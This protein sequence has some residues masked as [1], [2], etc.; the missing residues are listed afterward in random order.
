MSTKDFAKD[1]GDAQ[2]ELRRYCDLDAMYEDANEY[3]AAVKRDIDAGRLDLERDPVIRPVNPIVRMRLAGR[4][5]SCEARK[6]CNT[7]EIEELLCKC[8]AKL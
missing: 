3:I 1:N 2:R 6:P 8:L 5:E 4:F 7:K